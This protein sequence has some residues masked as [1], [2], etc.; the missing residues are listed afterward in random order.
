MQL[1][2]FILMTTQDKEFTFFHVFHDFLV[3]ESFWI[4]IPGFRSAKTIKLLYMV[5]NR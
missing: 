3:L 1:A 5:G 4:K 2:V